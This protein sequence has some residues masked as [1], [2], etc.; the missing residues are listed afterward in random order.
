MR[1]R[2]PDSPL[3]EGARFVET[4]SVALTEGPYSVRW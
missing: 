1:E 2:S 3:N 4:K